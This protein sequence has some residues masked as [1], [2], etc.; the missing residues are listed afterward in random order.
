MTTIFAPGTFD[1]GRLDE[2]TGAFAAATMSP[3]LFEIMAGN[4]MRVAE[5]EFALAQ[6]IMQVQFGMAEVLL[7]AGSPLDTRDRHARRATMAG[8]RETERGAA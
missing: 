6:A 8:R 5:A 1:P 2:A 4:M 3:V 7:R